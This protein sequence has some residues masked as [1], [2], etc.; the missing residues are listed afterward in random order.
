MFICFFATLLF[1][2]CN[3]ECET[4]DYSGTYDCEVAASWYNVMDS[5]GNG[6]SNYQTTL[7]V[8]Q[9]GDLITINDFTFH[10]DS[11]ANENLYSEYETGSTSK[12]VRFYAEDSIYYR[13][14]SGGLG[15][16]SSATYY[17]KKM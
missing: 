15:G 17:G 14:S 11:V 7:E 2:S 5:T 1:I 9:N 3:K 13:S 6:S 8:V 12:S 16:G 4:P 10:C